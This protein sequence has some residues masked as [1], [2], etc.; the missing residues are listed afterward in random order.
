MAIFFYKQL[1][2]CS[3]FSTAAHL[4]HFHFVFTVDVEKQGREDDED[5]NYSDGSHGVLEHDA[6]ED[7]GHHLPHCHDDHEGHGAEFVDGK[8][9][10]VLSDSRTD[11]EDNTVKEEPGVLGHEGERGVENSLLEQ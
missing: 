10:E 4:F 8:V 3:Y 9:N 5:A 6:G 7:D 2:P 11:A 1:P